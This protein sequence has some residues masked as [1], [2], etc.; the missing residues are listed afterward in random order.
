MKALLF[1]RDNV[2]E[3]EEANVSP[4][5]WIA[6]SPPIMVEASLNMTTQTQA[7]DSV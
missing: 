6:V 4:P 5:H 7:R 3:I 1:G 2:P